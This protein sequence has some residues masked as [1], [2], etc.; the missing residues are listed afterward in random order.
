MV[1][2]LRTLAAFPKNPG[3]NP[4]THT[5]DSG[6]RES[7]TFFS[8]HQALT[9][10]TD[11]LV[12]KTFIHIKLKKTRRKIAHHNFPCHERLYCVA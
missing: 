3:L 7:N 6:S 11:T 2:W 4:R 8:R 10:Y 5:D 1:Q 9:R 12:G